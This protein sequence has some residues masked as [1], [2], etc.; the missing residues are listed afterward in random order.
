MSINTYFQ[1]IQRILVDPSDKGQD[2]R[3]KLERIGVQGQAAAR[4]LAVCSAVIILASTISCIAR[5]ILGTFGLMVGTAF[6][7]ASYEGFIIARNVQV[8]ARGAIANVANL[9]NRVMNVVSPD[10]FMA[11]VL[12]D[13]LVTDVLFRKFIVEKLT[14][15]VIG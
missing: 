6:F 15:P 5:P 12:K 11:S 9:V 8:I 14:Q 1:N 2:I 13:T 3:K 7:L 10:A 4:D